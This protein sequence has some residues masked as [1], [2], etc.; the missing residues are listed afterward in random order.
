MRYCGSCAFYEQWSN[1]VL[2]TSSKSTVICRR[3]FLILCLVCYMYHPILC[4]NSVLACL[5][6]SSTTAPSAWCTGFLG[7]RVSHFSWSSIEYGCYETIAYSCT[8]I[9]CSDALYIYWTI[10]FTTSNNC[11][12]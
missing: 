1:E 10:L 9:L 3:M 6:H 12:C 5:T 11:S 7:P 8:I 2:M 4:V